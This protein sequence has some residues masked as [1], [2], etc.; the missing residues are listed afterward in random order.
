MGRVILT[1]LTKNLQHEFQ[2]KYETVEN[3][4]R[5]WVMCKC[6]WIG[7]LIQFGN[8]GGTKELSKLWD[9]HSKKSVRKRKQVPRD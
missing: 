3:Q 5:C 6:G 1:G 8:Y 2:L 7:E 4:E 9:E